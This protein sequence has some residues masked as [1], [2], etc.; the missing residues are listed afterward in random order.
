MAL[1]IPGTD[2]GFPIGGHQP[3]LEGMPTSDAG[4][5]Q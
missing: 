1:S 2:P 3:S 5:F 4:T